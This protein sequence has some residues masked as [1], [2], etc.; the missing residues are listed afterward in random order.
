MKR[1]FAKALPGADTVF[2]PDD[3]TEYENDAWDIRISL[4]NGPLEEAFYYTMEDPAAVDLSISQLIKHH[5][6]NPENIKNLQVADF[7][8]LPFIQT[9]LNLY[10]E[11]AR[12]GLLVVDF[13][14]NQ[15]P[16]SDA[17]DLNSK[18]RDLLGV[19]T[20]HDGSL[21]YRVLDLVLV[22]GPPNLG[23]FEID[24]LRRKYGQVYLLLLFSYKQCLG[25]LEFAHF[26]EEQPFIDF[27][28]NKFDSG[29]KNIIR[30][31]QSLEMKQ[32]VSISSGYGSD[33]TRPLIQLTD[34][35]HARSERYRNTAKEIA[36]NYDRY[37]SCSI[38]PPA[39]GIPGGFDVRVQMMELDGLNLSESILARVLED[40][41][42]EFFDGD[43]AQTYE[44]M[45]FYENVL[46]ALAYKTNFS[47]EVLKQLKKLGNGSS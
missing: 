39:L 25:T 37:D 47:L 31:I 23:T 16:E 8:D 2:R 3:I 35:G 34:E 45:D 38:T 29:Y 14:I 43:W 12:K 28:E 36:G 44:T 46:D 7:P 30:A 33:K 11:N 18:A 27:K 10:L 20:Y 21:D 40:F 13:F 5:A 15:A 9:E 22:A 17:I 32:L 26:L 42:K 1:K 6:L 24:D 4:A 19:C 41:G